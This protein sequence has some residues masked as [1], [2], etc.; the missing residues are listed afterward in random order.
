MQAGQHVDDAGL[1]MRSEFA[2]I[3]CYAVE[4]DEQ[5]Q[6]QQKLAVRIR[7]IFLPNKTT[8]TTRHQ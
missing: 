6:Q 5:Q 4:R 2:L 7:H 1:E 3:A 8:T